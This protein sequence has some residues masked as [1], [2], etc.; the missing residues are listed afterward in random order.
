[1]I[2]IREVE[3]IYFKHLTTPI[4]MD[5]GKIRPI[6]KKPEMWR[7]VMERYRSMQIIPITNDGTNVWIIS[8]LHYGHT[9]VIRYC[10]RPFADT[11]TMNKQLIEMH[12][13]VVKPNDL[14]IFVGDFAFL[15]DHEANAIIAQL[16]GKKNL[17]IGNHDLSRKGYVKQLDFRRMMFT[18]LIKYD[19]K[20]FAFSH[21]PMTGLPEPVF[22]IHG[23]VHNAKTQYTDSMFHFNVSCEVLDYKPVS[24]D[25]INQQATTRLISLD[26]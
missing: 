26:D 16:H 12:N 2:S 19:D 5:N 14:C 7:R 15:P 18:A 17:V 10:D 22:N 3:E 13:D 25:Y 21:Y 1:M 23:H 24:L 4:E 20:C 11:E 6:A 8:D 9:N